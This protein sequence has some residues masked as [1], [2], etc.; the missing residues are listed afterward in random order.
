MIEAIDLCEEIAGC[1]L[2]WKLSA[3]ARMGDHR[4]WISDL[5]EFQRD[6]PDWRQ[7]YGLGGILREIH[8]Q[9]ADRWLATA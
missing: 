2:R 8:D 6:Y 5:G 9:N 1:P 7:E 3:R 4:W